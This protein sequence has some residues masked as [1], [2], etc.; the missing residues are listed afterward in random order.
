MHGI[1]EGVEIVEAP[2]RD[3]QQ[4]SDEPQRGTLSQPSAQRQREVETRPHVHVQLGQQLHQ[5]GRPPMKGGW[6]R[7]SKMTPRRAAAG[8]AR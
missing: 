1:A 6:L 5:V 2:I 8:D 7:L 4:A 3:L